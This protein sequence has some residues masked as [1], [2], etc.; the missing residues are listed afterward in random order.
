MNLLTPDVLISAYAQGIFPMGVEGQ[1]QWF[2]PDPRAILPLN[3]FRC[4][5]TLRQT[6]RSD[7]FEIRIDTSFREVMLACGERGEGTWIMPELV[8]AYG[9]LA[10][11]GLAH[12][13]EAWQGGQLVGG[14][15]GVALGGAF[16]GESMFHH[17]R[18]ASKVALV[19]LVERM[20]TRGYTLMDIQYLTPHLESFGAVEIPR[21]DY[22]SRLAAALAVDCTFEGIPPPSST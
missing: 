10:R 8:R 16:F 4:S 6:V 13:V 15:Y 7:K 12:S 5:K 18:D 2:S 9:R 1:I 17:V 22:L 20:K 11:L 14:L 3:G 21:E 19:A